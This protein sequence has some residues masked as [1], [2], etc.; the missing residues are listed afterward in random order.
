MA[1]QKLKAR[2]ATRTSLSAGFAVPVFVIGA[3]AL[4][5][6]SQQDDRPVSAFAVGLPDADDDGIRDEF[7][8]SMFTD[9]NTWD[10]DG[11]TWSDAEEFSMNSNPNSSLVIPT[12]IPRLSTNLTARGENGRLH[13]MSAAYFMDAQNVS[14]A[15]FEL[16]LLIGRRY[17]KFSPNFL[18]INGESYS[19]AAR[20]IGSKVAFFEISFPDNIV[21][22]GGR[23][24]FLAMLTL[25]GDL[26]PSAISRLDVLMDAGSG[27]L[28]ME[29]PAHLMP[30]DPVTLNPFQSG[31]VYVPIPSTS[32]GPGGS[33]PVTWSPS[34]LCFKQTSTVGRAGALLVQEVTSARCVGGF[35]GYCAPPICFNT[36][37]DQF[38]TID[39]LALIGAQ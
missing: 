22:R 31:S 7:E 39:P 3:V 1:L 24:T 18:A 11:D 35:E 32:T 26:K 14:G 19:V 28:V 9:M 13:V 15:H 2:L 33:V 10:S 6:W 4:F 36:I 27:V 29:Y 20:P 8:R 12:V 23:V 5:A 37:G 38:Q 17:R 34:S 30:N 21:P 25:P 16:G